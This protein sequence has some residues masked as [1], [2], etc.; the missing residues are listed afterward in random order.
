MINVIP[1][2]A[3]RVFKGILF[4]VYQWKQKMLDGSVET[5]E[6][7]KRNHSVQVI[8]VLN[9]RIVL[10]T[11]EQPFIGKF[12]SLPGGIVDKGESPRAAA[13]RELLEETGLD[14][15]S[16]MLWR[17][18]SISSK[19]DWTTYYYIARDCKKISEPKNSPGERLVP[20]TVSFEG[21]LKETQKKRFRNK[22]FSEIIFREAASKQKKDALKKQIFK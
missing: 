17:K 11:E 1:R 8:A 18:A 22:S 2:N 9:N 7:V 19:V 12:V 20:F 13:R 6:A 21:F 16:L 15:S 4:D 5:F 14:C 10:L 3:K